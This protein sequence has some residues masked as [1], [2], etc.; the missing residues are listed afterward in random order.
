MPVA[1]S[2]QTKAANRGETHNF[3]DVVVL[4]GHGTRFA[5]S[6]TTDDVGPKEEI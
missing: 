2:R 1:S 6:V 3:A 4:G 5:P